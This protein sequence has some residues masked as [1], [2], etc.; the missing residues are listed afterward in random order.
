MSI[1]TTMKVKYKLWSFLLIL[2]F[3]VLKDN[4]AISGI[5]VDNKV[6][7]GDETSKNEWI[8]VIF[9]QTYIK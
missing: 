2:Y 8:D 3:L 6:F 7:Q 1:V 9:T 4:D 5:G